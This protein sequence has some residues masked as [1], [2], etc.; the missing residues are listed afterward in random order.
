VGDARS[1]HIAEYYFFTGGSAAIF[2]RSFDGLTQLT[3]GVVH[4]AKSTFPNSQ[5]SGRW[6]IG[7]AACHRAE[8]SAVPA[9]RPCLQGQ[10]GAGVERN[11][12]LLEGFGRAVRAALKTLG[13]YTTKKLDRCASTATPMPEFCRR[14]HIGFSPGLR[15]WVSPRASLR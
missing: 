5:N 3:P 7:L 11:G 4:T 1:R 14:D 13:G 2:K 8:A 6:G 12:R 15:I 10:C 9:A